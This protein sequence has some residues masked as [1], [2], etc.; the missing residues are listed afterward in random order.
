MRSEIR[1]N[2]TSILKGAEKIM[3][4][5]TP[6]GQTDRHTDGHADGH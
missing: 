5:P 4:P 2:Q 6:D 3:F 1:K